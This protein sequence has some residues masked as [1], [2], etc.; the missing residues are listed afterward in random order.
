MAC[1]LGA[2]SSFGI[3]N[4]ITAYILLV[5]AWVVAV[6]GIGAAE[7]LSSFPS[8]HRVLVWTSLSIFIGASLYATALWM[9]EKAY[10]AEHIVPD[11]L[12]SPQVSCSKSGDL[13]VFLGNTVVLSTDRYPF[14]VIGMGRDDPSGIYPILQID[15]RNGGISIRILRIF[16]KKGEVIT[17]IH[18][19]VDWHN[20]G[21]Y[22]KKL[23]PSTIVA[24][25]ETDRDVLRLH[26]LNKKSLV[27]TGI[28][29]RPGMIP[30]EVME[31][32]VNIDGISWTRM[33]FFNR[34]LVTDET[35]IETE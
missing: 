23:D 34:T 25:D 24:R 30:I 35:S 31:D 18:E 7:A 3:I 27:I 17:S 21:F 13:D 28:F 1:V 20:G 29:T 10:E 2:I 15:K 5:V 6:I 9:R 11:N 26:F 19:D 22:S 33:C 4:M 12:P 8:R 32:S 14:T 16:N